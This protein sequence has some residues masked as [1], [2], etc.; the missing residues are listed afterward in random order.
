MWLASK[1][2]TPPKEWC[3]NPEMVDLYCNTVAM[4]FASNGIIPPEDW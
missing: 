2:I 3:H 4:I 1:K